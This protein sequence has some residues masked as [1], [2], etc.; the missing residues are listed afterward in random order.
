LSKKK[1]L[2][3]EAK[4]RSLD[5]IRL[6]ESGEGMKNIAKMLEVCESATVDIVAKFV[7]GKGYN[8][9]KEKDESVKR[10]LKELRD[11]SEEDN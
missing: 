7:I 6:W 4:K 1:N 5:I 10:L 9:M 3:K 11:L 8:T 2:I